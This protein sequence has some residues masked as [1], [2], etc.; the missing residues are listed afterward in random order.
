L[1]DQIQTLIKEARDTKTKEESVPDPVRKAKSEQKHD[2]ADDSSDSSSDDET[3]GLRQGGKRGF[4]S[5]SNPKQNA[6][7]EFNSAMGLTNI[8]DDPQRY[9]MISSLV[10]GE[11]ADYG[12]V[13]QAYL[14]AQQDAESGKSTEEGW[15]DPVTELITDLESFTS[16]NQKQMQMLCHRYYKRF[17]QAGSQCAQIK[18]QEVSDLQA[19]LQKS[20]SAV[21]GTAVKLRDAG[22][23]LEAS[24]YVESQLNQ[25]KTFA[26][27]VLKPLQLMQTAEQQYERR[28]LLNA[29]TTIQ[30]VRETATP[31]VESPLGQYLLFDRVPQ[32]HQRI[33]AQSLQQLNLWCKV[34]RTE[35]EVIGKAAMNQR[36]IIFSVSNVTKAIEVTADGKGWR[37]RIDTQKQIASDADG[38]DAMTQVVEQLSNVSRGAGLQDLLTR[39]QHGDTFLR[40]VQTSR[41]R[42]LQLEIE[43]KNVEFEKFCHKVLGFM[44]VEDVCYHVTSPSVTTESRLHTQWSRII[45]E[46]GARALQKSSEP[47]DVVKKTLL[48]AR[49]FVDSAT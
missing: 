36:A 20:T 47:A 31:L 23:E 35:A 37:I 4:N 27:R 17:L 26:Q 38:R 8:T 15:V 22:S 2:A 46:V 16:D 21:M 42:Q 25:S 33:V 45:S 7:G 9:V 11:F 10:D 1:Y 3:A 24:R 32:L 29:I 34:L 48:I 19:A 41:D 39:C 30:L 43:D 28:Q 14:Q 40:N 13:K 6:V 49:Q 12:V 18:E 44:V 5:A